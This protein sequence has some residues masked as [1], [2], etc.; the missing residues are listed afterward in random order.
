MGIRAG[1][2]RYLTLLLIFAI[3]PLVPTV[4][5]GS[6]AVNLT[7]TIQSAS[8]D[9]ITATGVAV[10]DPI[11]V[12]FS[13]DPTQVGG[14]GTYTFTGSSKVHTFDLVVHDSMGNQVFHDFYTG[15]ITAL[16]VI[17]VTYGFTSNM[18]YP[19]VNGTELDINGDTLYNQGLGVSPGFDLSLFNPGNV[20]T[21]PTNPLPDSTLINNFTSNGTLL[22]WGV[23]NQTFTATFNF[24]S[25]PEP[26]TLLL[27]IVGIVT[28][29]LGFRNLRRDPRASARCQI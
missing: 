7:G 11:T 12:S 22:T 21:S 17:Q 28:T 3:G 14:G 23:G 13:Y 19:G 5:A 8:P 16:Y 24:Q 9:A 4:C 15:N 26:S 1:V 10:G 20:G 2:L 29:T 27:G 25:V 18:L 6:V